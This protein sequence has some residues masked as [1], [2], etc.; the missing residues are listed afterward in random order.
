MRN[1]GPGHRHRWWRKL[2]IG[3]PW[4]SS[5]GF[6]RPMRELFPPAR[7]AR[8]VDF[9]SV[10]GSPREL[11][12]E[13]DGANAEGGEEGAFHRVKKIADH[14]DAEDVLGPPVVA[15]DFVEWFGH[16]EVHVAEGVVN[17]FEDLV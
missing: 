12:K 2:K 5:S 10:T 14:I 7:T 6:G 16:D 8:V 13:N 11:I 9:K 1:V 15:D 3:W 17:F 4:T